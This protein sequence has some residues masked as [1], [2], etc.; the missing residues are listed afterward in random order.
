MRSKQSQTILNFLKNFKN[1]NN[2]LFLQHS[3]MFYKNH[4]NAL[5]KKNIWTVKNQKNQMIY[6]KAKFFNALDFSKHCEKMLR[7]NNKKQKVNKKILKFISD[8]SNVAEIF[9]FN[10]IYESSPL[11]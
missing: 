2:L 6:L 1:I 8:S 10:S 4:C 5:R 11:K 7:M 9:H 3:K